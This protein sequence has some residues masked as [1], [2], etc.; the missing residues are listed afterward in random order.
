MTKDK[1][2]MRVLPDEG[3]VSIQDLADYIHKKPYKVSALLKKKGVP[4]IRLGAYL[5]AK[6]VRIQDLK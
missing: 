5:C 1:L 4:I 3:V 6:L 2:K